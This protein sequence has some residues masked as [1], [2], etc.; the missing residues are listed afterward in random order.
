MD[1]RMREELKDRS[2]SLTSGLGSS[3]LLAI[4]FSYLI[5]IVA[6][7]YIQAYFLGYIPTVV[8]LGVIFTQVLLIHEKTHRT[9]YGPSKTIRKFRKWLPLLGFV[10]AMYLLLFFL[11]VDPTIQILSHPIFKNTERLL[12]VILGGFSPYIANTL[13][14]YSPVTEEAEETIWKLILVLLGTY[15][16]ATTIFG[17]VL[18]EE[19]SLSNASSEAVGTG[20]AI[21]GLALTVKYSIGDQRQNHPPRIQKKESQP[22]D[23][24][25]KTIRDNKS[26]T[27][28]AALLVGAG[29]PILSGVS[30]AVSIG[31]SPLPSGVAPG[32][33]VVG[34]VGLVPLASI[35]AALWLLPKVASYVLKVAVSISR[36]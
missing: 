17:G 26:L 28:L 24:Y 31:L 9:I 23:G 29:L 11:P 13:Y 14:D 12:M 15:I 36:P 25:L 34:Y 19:I 32:I 35:A 6:Q 4:G 18:L 21:F 27:F 20:L 22:L 7:E 16:L 33:F 30:T 2:L 3:F 10:W 8:G 5:S 1:Q